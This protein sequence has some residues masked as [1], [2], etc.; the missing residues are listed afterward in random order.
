MSTPIDACANTIA[1]ASEYELSKIV[2]DTS[3]TAVDM[4]AKE[5]AKKI[6]ASLD[7]GYTT[8]SVSAN[9]AAAI[10]EAH[11]ANGE[12]VAAEAAVAKATEIQAAAYVSYRNANAVSRRWY[13]ADVD[14]TKASAD[15]TKAAADTAID[16]IVAKKIAETTRESYKADC[17]VRD[18]ADKLYC[19]ACSDLRNAQDALNAAKDSKDSKASMKALG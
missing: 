12:V 18:A 1:C 8:F 11:A 7:A 15:A 5:I 4:V 13:K 2:T 16:A 14:A 19:S 10:A 3:A 9:D 17:I 6:S